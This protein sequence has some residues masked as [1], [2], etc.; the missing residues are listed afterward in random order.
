MFRGTGRAARCRCPMPLAPW[1]R[2]ARSNSPL[3]VATAALRDP[4]HPYIDAAR[5]YRK[6]KTLLAQGPRNPSLAAFLADL[7]ARGITITSDDD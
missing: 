1:R 2:I 5:D 3:T 6:R 7:D 4:M